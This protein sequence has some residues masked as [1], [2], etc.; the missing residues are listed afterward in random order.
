MPRSAIIAI[1]LAFG[2]A[3][4]VLGF[5]VPSPWPGV[6]QYFGGLALIIAFWLWCEW[7]VRSR[8]TETESRA[9]EA[10]KRTRL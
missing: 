7:P 8:S 1:S 6:C 3:L 5:V 2:A 10:R 4:F 9:L